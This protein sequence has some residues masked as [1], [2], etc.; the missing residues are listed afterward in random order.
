[1]DLLCFCSGY[2]A[3]Y[4]NSDVLLYL[5]DRMGFGA[6]WKK[7]IQNCIST[8]RF[9]VLISGSPSWFFGSSRGLRQGDPL[10]LFLVM[11]VIEVLSRML[12][13]TE[14]GA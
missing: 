7:W 1:M 6:K 2:G 13:C 11:L 14:E 9:S 8:V 5:M 10:S 3:T 12:K 4:V